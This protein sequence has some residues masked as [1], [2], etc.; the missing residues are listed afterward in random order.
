MSAFGLLQDN[1]L[2]KHLKFCLDRSSSGDK[3]DVFGSQKGFTIGQ[4][5]NIGQ[6]Y[7]Y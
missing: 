6:C 4:K 5:K 3:K 2:T 1:N 7:F